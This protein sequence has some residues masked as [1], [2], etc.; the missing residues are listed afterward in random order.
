M[1]NLIAERH[2][3]IPSAKVA[4][5]DLGKTIVV[6]PDASIV[7]ARSEKTL[8]AATF[9]RRWG[10]HSLTAWCDNTQESLA[11]KLQAGNAGSNTVTDHIEVLTAAIKPD[12]GGLP[13][14]PAGPHH[15]V[16]RRAGRRVHYSVRREGQAADSAGRV[17]PIPLARSPGPVSP[18][19]K[20]E[21]KD[22]TSYRQSQ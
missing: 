8:A 7:I 15:R 3:A 10:H 22:A 16:E 12:P 20:D 17:L 21:A 18:P 9:K 2:G 14:G 19:S 6:R 4:V 13:A 5:A 11:V 1:W